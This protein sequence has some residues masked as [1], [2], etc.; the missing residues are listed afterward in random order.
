MLI[1]APNMIAFGN[2]PK[3]PKLIVRSECRVSTAHIPE[4]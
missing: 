4:V 2:E 3:T 1:N